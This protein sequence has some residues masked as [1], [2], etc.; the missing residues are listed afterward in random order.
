[1]QGYV[2]KDSFVIFILHPNYL[3]LKHELFDCTNKVSVF[4]VKFD[5]SDLG[6]NLKV[7][8]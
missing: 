8:L 2:P 7:E 1:M 5:I 4:I 3:P 6:R